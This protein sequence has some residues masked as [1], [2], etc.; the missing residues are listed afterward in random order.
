MTEN[1]ITIASD[2]DLTNAGIRAE[3]FAILAHQEAEE[4]N[5][6]DRLWRQCKR[7]ANVLRA[8][9]SA[10][11]PKIATAEE[12]GKSIAT[13]TAEVL[14]KGDDEETIAYRKKIADTPSNKPGGLKLSA[15]AVVMRADA[16]TLA[17]DLTEEGVEPSEDLVALTFRFTS[18]GVNKTQMDAVRNGGILFEV[19]D[20]KTVVDKIEVAPVTIANAL[21]GMRGIITSLD[22]GK[23]RSKPGR[24][25]TPPAGNGAPVATDPKSVLKFLATLKP[26]EWSDDDKATLNAWCKGTMQDLKK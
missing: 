10:G 20:G 7:A 12:Y 22:E 17:E 19:K 16:W 14:Y 23:E 24:A 18:T 1:I 11:L 13:A 2:V 5:A 15:N 4:S 25:A 9:E 8:A 26:S 21:D 6:L 3:Q